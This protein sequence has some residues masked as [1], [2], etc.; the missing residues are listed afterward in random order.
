LTE[1]CMGLRGSA[2]ATLGQ[3]HQAPKAQPAS[4]KGKP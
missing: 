4:P 1:A 3:A 2:L